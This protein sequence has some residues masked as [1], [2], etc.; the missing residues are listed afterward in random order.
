MA[1]LL[2]CG[3]VAADWPQFRGP[4]G[5]GIADDHPLPEQFG[6]STNLVW[7]TAV[8]PG[9]SSPVIAGDR[10]FM[11]AYES[12]R[13]LVL[14]VDRGTGEIE[15]MREAPRP[16]REHFQPTHGPASPTPVTD[17]ENVYVFFGDFGALSYDADGNERWRHAMGPFVNQNGHGSSP[18][19][20]DGKLLIVCDQQVGSF[21]IA[22]DPGTGETLW[23]ADRPATTRGYGTAGIFRPR[24]GRPQVVVPGAYRVSAYD[25]GTGEEL[26]WV[27]GFAW[28]LKCVPLFDSDTVYI[29]GWEIGGDPGQQQETP[30]FATVLEAHD[31]DGDGLLSFAEAP[32]ERLRSA[33]PWSEADLGGDGKMDERDWNFY[34]ARRAPINNLV[35]IRPG[36]LRG[37]ITD[38]G[39]AWRYTKALP[40]TPSPLLYR[41]RLFLVKDGGIFSSVDPGEGVSLKVGRLRE[42]ID[43]YWAS[44]VAGDGKIFTVSEGCMIS[45]IVPEADWS[46]IA[47]SSLDGTCFA[48]P[49]IV[50][51]RMYVRSL[52]ALYSFSRQ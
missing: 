12:E 39:V 33:R 6:E 4:G 11:T 25:L 20:A 1:A 8:P 42:A 18:V 35:A 2:V 30:P 16:R 17:G 40:N 14:A 37:D 27:R 34:A 32:D 48:T 31:K 29:N 45:A 52:Q 46:V 5:T 51:G 47:T 24:G 15:W 9:H 49:A 36:S 41:G 22:L 21:L 10:I 50:D 38:S 28:Q 26:W 13:L 43:K 44:P 19:L 3:T 23:K 7:K